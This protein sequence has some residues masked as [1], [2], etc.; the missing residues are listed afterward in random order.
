MLYH[1]RIVGPT[2]LVLAIKSPYPPVASNPTG[3]PDDGAYDMKVED[4]APIVCQFGKDY[5]L[6]SHDAAVKIKAELDRYA[7]LKVTDD[8]IEKI[9]ALVKDYRAGA[10][11]EKITQ[12]IIDEMD[13]L[14]GI[15]NDM[16]IQN[17]QPLAPYQAS[18]PTNLNPFRGLGGGIGGGQV[19]M[20]N[21]SCVPIG[22]MQPYDSRYFSSDWLMLD[23]LFVSESTYSDLY[24]LLKNNTMYTM[25]NNY[26]FNEVT[27]PI[28]N[29]TMF[30]LPNRPGFMIK[31]L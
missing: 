23:G 10:S 11:L 25:Y 18:P 4:A 20:K 26:Q 14:A 13:L 9:T 2:G 1:K 24:T 31:A 22:D 21:L 30:E 5:T 28:T 19:P 16:L 17:L 29:Q 6:S 3:E 27:D 8:K 15:L 12:K 7:L